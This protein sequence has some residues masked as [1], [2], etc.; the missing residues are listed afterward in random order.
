MLWLEKR[1]RFLVKLLGAVP[2][3][4]AISV[5]RECATTVLWTGRVSITDVSK[6]EKNH[7]TTFFK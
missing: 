7:L 1:Q 6:V 3:A 4:R 2:C 5:T